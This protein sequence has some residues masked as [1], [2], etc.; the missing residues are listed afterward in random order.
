MQGGLT[1][2][3]LLDFDLNNSFIA[4]G[5]TKSPDGI[6]GFNFKP[7]IRAVNNSLAGSVSGIVTDSESGMPLEGVLISIVFGDESATAVTDVNGYYEILGLMEENY[8]ISA[9]LEGF[10]EG[11]DYC[12][13]TANNKSKVNFELNK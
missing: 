6:N 4:Q 3:L 10:S 1:A 11:Q 12:E 7:V 9:Y 2:E 8:S 13:I 5:D